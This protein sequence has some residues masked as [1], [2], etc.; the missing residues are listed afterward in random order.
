[1]ARHNLKSLGLSSLFFAAL[2]SML[3]TSACVASSEDSPCVLGDAADSEHGEGACEDEG[4]EASADV[5]A[6]DEED[7]PALKA[8]AL[9]PQWMCAPICDRP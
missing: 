3:S 6:S 4:A 8:P 7:A 2:A 9:E 1:M 5:E